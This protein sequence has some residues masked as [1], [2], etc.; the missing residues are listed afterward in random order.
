V[1]L[2]HWSI[3]LPPAWASRGAMRRSRLKP[4][5]DVMQ[6]NCEVE[7]DRSWS[8]RRW[9]TDSISNASSSPWMRGMRTLITLDANGSL[10]KYTSSSP[11]AAQ[12]WY[13]P[14]NTTSSSAP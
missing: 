5:T 4:I 1:V 13:G 2:A 8:S 14:T 11:S 6:L 12:I 7:R 9:P 10:M 3:Q